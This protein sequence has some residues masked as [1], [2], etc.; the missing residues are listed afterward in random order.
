VGICT[1]PV[2][3]LD[4]VSEMAYNVSLNHHFGSTGAG[5]SQCQ[6]WACYVGDTL[7]KAIP[8]AA[9]GTLIPPYLT[10]V[11]DTPPGLLSLSVAPPV[12]DWRRH[13][14]HLPDSIWRY[15]P[16]QSDTDK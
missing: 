4:I 12:V 15:Q 9:F 2:K 10:H 7:P 1:A 3:T 5:N 6:W 16:N 14:R 11:G 13:W 8:L